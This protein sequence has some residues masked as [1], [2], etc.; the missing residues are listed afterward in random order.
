MKRLK[1]APDFSL[2]P[3]AV[4]ETFGILAVRGAGKSNTAA[5]MAEEMFAAGLPFVV[6]DPVGSW[7]GLR[8]SADGTGPGLSIPIFGGKHGDVPLRRE[9]GA[10]VADL[11]VDQRMSCVL[12][13]SEFESEAAK[14]QFLLD[15]ARRL[16]QRNT[17]PLHLFLEEADDY[18]PQQ[19]M[20]G[21]NEKRIEPQL[22]RAFENLVRRGRARGLGMTLITQRSASLNKNVLT[23]VQTLIAMRTTGPQDRQA[24]E[25]W[26]KYHDQ[27]RDILASLSSLKNGEAWVWSPE[28]LQATERVRFRQRATFD[29][30]A[31]PKMTK[32]SRPAAT[33]ADVDVALINQRMAATIEKAKAEDP[34]ELRRE[35]AHLKSELTVATKKTQPAPGTTTVERV[36]VKVPVLDAGL[37]HRYEEAADRLFQAT[38]EARAA[39]AECQS[40]HQEVRQILDAARQLAAY[41]P[42]PTRAALPSRAAPAPASTRAA[43]SRRA[44]TDTGEATVGRGGLRRML[45]ALAQVPQGLSAAKMGIR[46]G[47]SYRSGTW[48]TYIGRA[49]KAGWIE[50]T[51]Q[52]YTIT[53]E[54]LAA[55]G[56]YDPLP[57]GQALLDHWLREFGSGGQ[58]RILE[59]LAHVYPKT[60][61]REELG[62][63]VDMSFT[64]GTWDTYIGRLKKL[65]LIEAVGRGEF[66]A[67][68]EL[69]S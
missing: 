16:Y 63:A 66:R 32:G 53:D 23:Q 21:G 48:D 20:G 69:F 3:E 30:G 65:D 27:S 64:S 22:L 8:S 68:E 29:S 49:K 37:L 47:M 46:A 25:A 45:T 9:G 62:E 52:Q 39:A 40:L 14:K 33:L 10:L 55:L 41:R 6:V 50:G 28:F 5:V 18:I 59:A 35:I 19:M 57:T 58:A 17:E 51:S 2:P 34:K 4:T 1:L 67:S 26:I 54:G 15:F 38:T 24:I 12:D 60:M 31:T 44:E 36:E 11:V 61:T 7:W 43:P 13:L 42:S 56:P